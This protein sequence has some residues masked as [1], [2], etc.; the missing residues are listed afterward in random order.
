MAIRVIITNEDPDERLPVS[1]TTEPAGTQSGAPV[2][3]KSSEK[4]SDKGQIVA[5]LVA[6][7]QV[8]PYVQSA[9]NFEVSQ[10]A[11]NTGS[12]ELQ[13]RAQILSGL[14]STGISIGLG[15]AVGGLKGVAVSAAL[16]A[17]QSTITFVQN[18][19]AIENQ[20]RLEAENIYLRRSRLGSTVNR[21]RTGGIA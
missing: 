4:K 20:R 21:S 2:S 1:T 13:Q 8:M 5:G 12:A 15:A 18:R 9:I 3:Q 6:V 17:V 10:I 11:Y 7:Q 19:Q 14:A 16:A